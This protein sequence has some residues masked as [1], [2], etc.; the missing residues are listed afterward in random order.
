MPHRFEAGTVNAGGAVGLAAAID[1]I[2]EIG[3]ETIQK[4]E[5]E[6]TEIALNEMNKTP[7]VKIIGA[8]DASDHHGI[9]TFT[10]DGVHP[11]DIAAI[12]DADN[13]AIRAGHH[14]AQPLHQYLDVQ[15]TARM[16]LAFYNDEQDITRFIQTLRS[17]R[18]RMG[19]DN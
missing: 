11:H 16:S 17:I 13:I 3:F 8:N 5:N 19:Y 1:Y 10:I 18:R 9:L 14:C 6:L 12:F 2:K 4:R 7:H 15:S